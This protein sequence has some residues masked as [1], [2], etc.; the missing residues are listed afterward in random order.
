MHIGFNSCRSSGDAAHQPLGK[1]TAGVVTLVALA[2]IAG[3]V[4]LLHH[5]GTTPQF[6][7]GWVLAGGGT[8]AL[9]AVVLDQLL[10][11]KRVSPIDRGDLEGALEEL[12][13]LSQRKAIKPELIHKVERELRHKIS[14]MSPEQLRDTVKMINS[15]PCT[16]TLRLAAIVCHEHNRRVEGGCEWMRT[17]PQATTE[18]Q[19]D[20]PNQTLDAYIEQN[21]PKRVWRHD[22]IGPSG[23]QEAIRSF[24]YSREHTGVVLLNWAD[25]ASIVHRT[26]I[27]LEKDQDDHPRILLC[28]SLGDRGNGSVKFTQML[29]K[30]CREKAGVND[31]YA[32]QPLRQRSNTGCELFA[33]NDLFALIDSPVDL[34]SLETTR[35]RNGIYWVD[36]P[37]TDMI[38]MAQSRAQVETFMQRDGDQIIR[39]QPLPVAGITPGETTLKDFKKKM[40][41]YTPHGQQNIYNELVRARLI[42]FSLDHQIALAAG[43]S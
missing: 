35:D 28:D 20:F 6:T 14:E 4:I 38:K 15:Y 2:A 33:L 34:T 27:Y 7:A 25:D 8:L 1:V 18:I 19:V 11:G 21:L 39:S 31:V 37:T 24:E 41:H 26:L 13:A 42:E 9:S 40:F 29:A 36:V 17:T 16:V 30:W 5:A 3:G 23:L 10:C 32:I 22:T 12:Q 43:H